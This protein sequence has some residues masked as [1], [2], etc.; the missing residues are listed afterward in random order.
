M[1]AHRQFCEAVGLP[2][3]EEM[4]R[5]QPGEPEAWKKWPGWHDSA[6]NSTGF[7]AKSRRDA[8][9][10]EEEL[11]PEV[12]AYIERSMSIYERLHSLRLI[13]KA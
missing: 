1:E 4:L 8:K 7:V 13:P 11:P 2:F 6:I 3:S 12:L 9:E 5:W 10:E